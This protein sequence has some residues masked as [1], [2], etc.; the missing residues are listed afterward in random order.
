MNSRD[1]F[2]RQVAKAIEYAQKDSERHESFIFGLSAKWGEGKT[3]FIESLS[4]E[5]GDNWTRFDINPWKYSNDKTTFLQ[6][7]LISL[8]TNKDKV[9]K[10]EAKN[11]I[12]WKASKASLIAIIVFVLFAAALTTI[13]FITA[14]PVGLNTLFTLVITGVLIPVSISLFSK[15]STTTSTDRQSSALIDFDDLLGAALKEHENK[16]ILV[17][18]D[19]LDR[20]SARSAIEVLDNMRTFFDRSELSFI[21]SGDHSV[22]ER[23][24]G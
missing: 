11:K 4:K 10:T 14:I 19:D 12:D 22:M 8:G 9:L 1:E 7:F 2:V 20:V 5:L 23:H 24:I 13:N 6:A 21:V 15:T 17:V 3:T 16:R 18:V